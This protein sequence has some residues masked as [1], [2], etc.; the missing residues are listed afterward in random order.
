MRE[1]LMD[2]YTDKAKAIGG[3]W[4]HGWYYK[5]DWKEHKH[6]LRVQKDSHFKDY[7]IDPKTL[8][9]CTGLKDK[10]GVLIYEGDVV[11]VR[12]GEQFHGHW[13][14]DYKE[15]VKDIRYIGFE[16]AGEY[17]HVEIISNIHD[18]EDQQ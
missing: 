16:I 1:D 18:K 6:W 9:Q 7:A 3:N 8:C 5:C 11:H 15:T 10:N 12:G 14:I 4:L 13:E 2:R 17:D